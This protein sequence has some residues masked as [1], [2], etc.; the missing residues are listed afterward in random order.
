MA[1]LGV[2]ATVR[3]S[4]YLYSI[5]EEVDRLVDGPPQGQ[6]EPRLAVSEFDQLYRE[7]ILDHYKNPRNHGLLDP[8]DAQAEGQNPLCGD[9]ITVSVRLGDGDVIE[10]V[11]FDGRGC[12]I[13]QAATSML[14]DLVKGRTAEEVAAMPKDELL[15]ELGIPLTPVR[16]KCAILGLGV[17]KLALH[18]A[19]GTPLPEEWGTSSREPGARVGGES[20]SLG[21]RSLPPGS[22]RLV[23]GR[24]ARRSASTTATGRLHADRGSL[25]PRRRAAL[26]RRLGARS[27]RRRLP[28]TRLAVRPRERDTR[29]RCRRSRRCPIYPVSV[30]D[31]RRIVVVQVPDVMLDERVLGVLARLEAEDDAERDA[32]L[33]A[34][35]AVAPGRADHRTLPLRARRAARRA[36]KCS[37]IGGSRGYSSIWLA[38]ARAVLGGRLRRSS[39]IPVKCE[40][41][42]ANIADAGS[43]RVGG[44]RRGRRSSRRC[45]SIQDTF[46]LVFLDAEKDDYEALFGLARPLLEPGGL[47]IADNVL[48]HAETLG[49]VLG[50]AP[51]RSDAVERH[52]PARSRARAVRSC[53]SLTVDRYGAAV[54]ASSQPFLHPL[55][56]RMLALPRKGGGPSLSDD[57]TGSGGTSG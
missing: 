30:R 9:E 41:W 19:R 3:A 29:C 53:L 56:V 35:A 31:G 45:E 42:R 32:G 14:S 46:D 21:S 57:S 2:A 48:S 18:K 50:G 23:A 22:M 26:R 47:V 38:A 34:G 51:G 11:G 24:V 49:C 1:K 40:A 37:E 39:T 12:A 20:K 4:F 33:P 54:E 6:E 15:D 28:A 7:L 27:L 5:P 10:E 36:S 43:R 25:L 17:L 16:L 8:A 13:S 44:A 52:R 55:A